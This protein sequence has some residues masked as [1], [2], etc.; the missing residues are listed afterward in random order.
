MSS[1]KQ[2]LTLKSWFIFNAALYILVGL[3]FLVDPVALG[4]PVASSGDIFT[5]HAWRSYA[6]VYIGF[7]IIYWFARNDGP[8]DTQK[9]IMYG[10]LISNFLAI[11]IIL[12]SII[13]EI[14]NIFAW[15]SLVLEAIITVGWGYWI[16]RARSAK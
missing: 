4:A 16:L 6:S 14:V 11:G 1:L 10:S 5:I 13:N 3:P 9:G 2:Y 7:G 15:G 8:S 12:L